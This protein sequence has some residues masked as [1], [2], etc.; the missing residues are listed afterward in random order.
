M[1]MPTGKY[2][3]MMTPPTPW[4][5]EVDRHPTSSGCHVRDPTP[6]T[7][8]VDRHTTSSG[9]QVRVGIGTEEPY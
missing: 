6:W 7:I 8:E 9:S 5:F 1:D 2:L 4:T 3:K